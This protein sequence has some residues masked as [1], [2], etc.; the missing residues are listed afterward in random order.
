MAHT[1][2]C[3]SLESVALPCLRPKKPSCRRLREAAAVR[4]CARQSELNPPRATSWSGGRFRIVYRM[5]SEYCDFSYSG[6]LLDFQGC[7]LIPLSSAPKACPLPED[8]SNCPHLR[9][10]TQT[11]LMVS[12]PC[13]CVRVPS[14]ANMSPAWV[15]T[16][17]AVRLFV[18]AMQGRSGDGSADEVK[19]LLTL[20]PPFL[21]P[22]SSNKSLPTSNCGSSIYFPTTVSIASCH[23][24][25]LVARHEYYCR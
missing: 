13:C 3:S 12:F 16:W 11:T 25:S 19:L 18:D 1:P 6:A 24:F 5:S 7:E 10:L 22:P 8:V 15:E 23:A 2:C 4:L 9:F 21:Y 20:L 14:G 17:T